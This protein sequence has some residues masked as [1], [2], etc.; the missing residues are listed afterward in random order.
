MSKHPDGKTCRDCRFFASKCEWLLSYTGDET[1]CDWDPSR[2]APRRLIEIVGPST[3]LNGVERPGTVHYR[4]ME[5]DPLI[6]E[7]IKTP[8]YSVRV[9]GDIH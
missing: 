7:A 9:A 1:A 2:F 3:F 6:D 8:G 4:R 5:G